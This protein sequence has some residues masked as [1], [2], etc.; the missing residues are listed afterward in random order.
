MSMLPETETAATIDDLY[1]V[2][3]QAELIGG[4]IV[5]YPPA[6]RKPNRVAGRVARSLNAYAEASGRGEVYTHTLVFTVPELGSGRK[7]FSPD[8]SYYDGLFPDD[9]MRFIEGPPTFAVK[10]RSENDSGPAAEEAMAAKRADYFEAGTP[11]VWDVDPEAET[12]AVYRAGAAMT[13]VVYR[14]GKVA[15]A[16]PAPGWRMAVDAI[17]A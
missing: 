2:E 7:S 10:V 9:A 5:R 3:G 1:R 6:G 16:D 4:R 17:F 8:V 15:E 12:V 11:V 13:P 14:R